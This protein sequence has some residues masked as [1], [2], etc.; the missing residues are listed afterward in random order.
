MARIFRSWDS[1][2][3]SLIQ[4]NKYSA[5]NHRWTNTIVDTVGDASTFGDAINREFP[6]MR[7]SQAGGQ[8]TDDQTKVRENHIRRMIMAPLSPRKPIEIPGSAVAVK[9]RDKQRLEKIVRQRRAA[10]AQAKFSLEIEQKDNTNIVRQTAV[11]K[12][13]FSANRPRRPT[14][15]WGA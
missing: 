10:F 9:K 13:D 15:Y 2:L 11:R 4:T 5:A 3:E 12:R 8:A 7:T 6:H 14:F 1:A